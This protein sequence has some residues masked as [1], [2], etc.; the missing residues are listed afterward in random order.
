MKK[1]SKVL[2]LLL[3]VVFAAFAL[4]ACGANEGTGANKVTIVVIDEN[5]TELFNKTFKTD[6]A[7]LKDVFDEKQIPYTMDASGTMVSSIYDKANPADWS[8]CWMFYTNADGMTD[9]TY[10]YTYKDVQYGSASYGATELQMKDGATY[11]V[12]F[13]KF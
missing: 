11:V 10:P 7:T 12:V 3:V 1:L 13:V 9:G 8:Y 4:S 6:S 5:G 2:V